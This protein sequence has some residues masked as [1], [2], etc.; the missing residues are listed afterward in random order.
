VDGVVLPESPIDAIG[1][2][3]A[4]GVA[5]IVGTTRDEMRLFSLLDPGLNALDEDRLTARLGAMLHDKNAARALIADYRSRRPDAS[6]TDLWTELQTDQV[7]RIPAVRLAERQS[8][9]GNDVYMYRFDYATPA[10]GG[11]LG[12]C[13]ALEI[14]FVF[15][16]LDSGASHLFVGDIT[17]DLRGLAERMHAA[18]VAFAR[19]GRPVA[20]HLPEWPRYTEAHRSTMLFDLAPSVVDD[21]AGEDRQ[22]WAGRL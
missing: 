10:F 11:Q 22:A 5:V 18:W 9:L 6:V 16:S 20:A 7:F 21:P 12:A 14:P 4:A 13:H 17:A 1:K 3:Q 15:K 2:G 19:T 8:A